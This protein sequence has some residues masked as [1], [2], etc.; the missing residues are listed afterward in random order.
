MHERYTRPQNIDE[1]Q[2]SGKDAAELVRRVVAGED[3]QTW[4]SAMPERRRDFVKAL[5]RPTMQQLRFMAARVARDPGYL[6]SVLPSHRVRVQQ[7]ADTLIRE[8]GDRS[9]E[10]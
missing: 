6:D 1:L 7:Y 10:T 9:S 2:G 8:A 5:A 3:W 4:L